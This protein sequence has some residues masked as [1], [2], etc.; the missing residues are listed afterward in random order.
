MINIYDKQKNT[1]LNLN[2]K[3]N[4]KYSQR[5]LNNYTQ[6]PPCI[7]SNYTLCYNTIAVA[8]ANDIYW[9]F[10]VRLIG[11]SAAVCGIVYV[12]VSVSHKS[13]KTI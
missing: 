10:L 5:K 6:A 1:K 12:F 8:L 13:R 3:T 4:L 11:W 2:N 9:S 7:G